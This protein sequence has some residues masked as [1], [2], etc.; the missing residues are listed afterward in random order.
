MTHWATWSSLHSGRIVSAWDAIKRVS[1][2]DAICG[3]W[4]SFDD[5]R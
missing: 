5:T 3:C 2:G 4:A 1:S